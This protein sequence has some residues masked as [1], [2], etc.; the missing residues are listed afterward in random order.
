MRLELY[1][2]GRF[3]ASE[4]ITVLE[5]EMW[6]DFEEVCR[7]REVYTRWMVE[8]LKNKYARAIENSEYEIFLVIAEEIFEPELN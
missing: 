2:R 3:Y 8:A 7:A 4:I 6:I 5:K 1:I